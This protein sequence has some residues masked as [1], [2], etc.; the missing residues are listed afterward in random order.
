L[1]KTNSKQLKKAI[2]THQ[3]SQKQEGKI[4]NGC[5]ELRSFKLIA[6]TMTVMGEYLENNL[7]S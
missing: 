4:H 1:L 6:P 7:R 5:L 3:K 2:F